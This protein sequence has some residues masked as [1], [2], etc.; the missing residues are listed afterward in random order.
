MMQSTY[1]KRA[2]IFS[3]RF[4]DV[5]EDGSQNED[6]IEE[7]ADADWDEPLPVSV[8]TSPDEAILLQR[9]LSASSIFFS[10]DEQQQ[11]S[12]VNGGRSRSLARGT[13]TR[14]ASSTP[15]LRISRQH[16]IRSSYAGTS[17]NKTKD[18][19]RIFGKSRIPR[20]VYS[21]NTPDSNGRSR[22][23]ISAGAA[24]KMHRL[25]RKKSEKKVAPPAA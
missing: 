9:C 16:H 15:N 21:F 17:N 20:G 24:K 23:T 7:T 4:Y 3:R 11:Y 12:N 6:E 18:W 8:A 1:S 14:V 2:S 25:Q 13:T 22:P 10:E 19:Q 5:D